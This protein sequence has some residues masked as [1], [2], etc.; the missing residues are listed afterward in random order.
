VLAALLFMKRMAELTQ[1]RLGLSE[2]GSD[3]DRDLPEGV[4]RY[5]IAGPLFFGAAQHAM[6]Q[7]DRLRPDVRVIILDLSRVPAIDATGLVALESACES[8]YKAKRRV[9]ICGPLPEPRRVFDKAELSR[10]YL[11]AGIDEA[12]KLARELA[13]ATSDADVPPPSL[14][15]P[16][17]A[18]PP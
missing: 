6:G 2:G 16:A 12:K 7:I 15:H 5:E 9:I 3:T 8:L 10:A 13:A 4:V 11:A 18:P 14:S 17:P 1:G